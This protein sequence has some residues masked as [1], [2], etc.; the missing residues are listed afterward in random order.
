M[1]SG[2]QAS[3]VIPAQAEAKL[4]VRLLP[5]E[6][7]ETFLAGLRSVIGDPKVAIEVEHIPLPQVTTESDTEFYRALVETLQA[8]G[9]PG[10]ISPY[11]T[12]GATDSRFFRAAGMKAYGFMPMLLDD[13]ELSRVHGIDERIST[14]NLRWGIQMV[15]ETLQKL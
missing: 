10:T 9:P 4:D 15:F 14:A 5:D 3:N 1:L 2:G 6:D 12:P 13:R 11:L 7:P 8:I